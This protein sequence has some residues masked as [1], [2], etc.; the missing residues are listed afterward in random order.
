MTHQPTVL[1][2]PTKPSSY[3]IQNVPERLTVDVPRSI[4]KNV[5]SSKKQTDVQ[6]GF[7]YQT[8]SMAISKIST[9]LGESK[10]DL[11]LLDQVYEIAKAEEGNC[12]EGGRLQIEFTKPMIDLILTSFL[13]YGL[14]ENLARSTL[15]QLQSQ[16]KLPIEGQSIPNPALLLKTNIN[17]YSNYIQYT[18]GSRITDIVS[19]PSNSVYKNTIGYDTTK[20]SIYY[21][22]SYSDGSLG[23]LLNVYSWIRYTN[24]SSQKK[25]TMNID[26]VQVQD[27]LQTKNKETFTVE[28]CNISERCSKIKSVSEVLYPKINN[29]VTTYLYDVQ[30]TIEGKLDNHGGYLISTFKSGVPYTSTPQIKYQELFDKDGNLS[31]YQKEDSTFLNYPLIPENHNYTDYQITDSI[32][33]VLLEDIDRA[34]KVGNGTN[35]FDL[36]I[37]AKGNCNPNLDTQC[38]LGLGEF[39]DTREVL[40]CFSTGGEITCEYDN[41]NQVTFSPERY[42]LEVSIYYFGKETDIDFA[43]VWRVSYNS[44]M[45][46]IYTKLGDK[47]QKVGIL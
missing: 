45:Q 17:G 11:I 38:I 12:V 13:D 4:R 36:F 34:N 7:G 5:N 23:S 33:V 24:T 43:E 29:S 46:A 47:I 41:D 9:L 1:Q 14:D 25:M 18:A 40:D 28:S 16:G 42:N 20:E 15:K 27:K 6:Q 39:V 37:I 30:A 19:C 26:T 21:S 2:P 8:F 32:K 31:A 44:S 35:G 3:S 22:A 10:R